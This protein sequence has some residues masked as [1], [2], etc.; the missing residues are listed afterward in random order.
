M[1]TTYL[2]DELLVLHGPVTLPEIPGYGPQ[3]PSNALILANP[4][5]AP[6]AGHVWHL[7]NG[8][9]KQ[10]ED[11]RGTVYR[12]PNGTPESYW[13]LGPLPADLTTLTRPSDSHIWTN[14]AWSLDLTQL[15]AGKVAE[16]NTA[17]TTGI[18]G[19]FASS[20]LGTTHRY[21]SAL[22]DQL[23]L[24]GLILSGA[25]SLCSCRD[26]QGVKAYRPHTA[27][28]LRQVGDDFTAFKLVWLHH[29]NSLKQQLDQALANTDRVALEAISWTVPA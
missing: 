24:T 17:C 26:E 23:N 12:L 10:I 18:T 21:G 7:V 25:D 4:L 28:Q 27:T 9:P 8:K 16:V 5:P 11:R 14:G 20:A 29:A 22:D 13:R 2:I 6:K 19:G 15:H 1:T 3:S